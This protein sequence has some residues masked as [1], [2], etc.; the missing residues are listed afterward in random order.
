MIVSLGSGCED[1]GPDIDI[2]SAVPVDV[3]DISLKPIREYVFATG[4]VL[5]TED[6]QL[7]AEQG[8]YYRLKTNPETGKPF[9]MG[10]EVKKG[11]LIV[12]L[13]NP[14][15]V[16]SVQFDSKKI[17][18]DISQREYEKQQTLYDKGGVT[19]RELTDAEQ[20]FIN[21]RYAYDNA[22]LQL[23][24]LS[25]TAPFDGIIVDLNYYSP[26]QKVDVGA[27]IARV[28]NYAQL[29]S[30]V[31]L[32]GK[33]MGRIHVGQEALVTNYAYPDDTLSGEVSQ[34]SPALD[35]DSRTF[36][37][38]V[39]VENPELILRPGMFVKIDIVAAQKDSAVVIPKDII[40]DRRGAK[41]VF[42]VEKGIAM[43]RKIETGLSNRTE[44]EVTS[45]L[46]DG[47]RLVT[48]GYETLQNR[49]RIKVVK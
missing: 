20:T 31:S 3:E 42:V 32:P 39:A 36:K 43:E 27:N 11:D 33:E 26:G 5:A 14:E 48:R 29:Y 34:L 46:K 40:L 2:E 1:D 28:M 37:V 47:E 12:H 45:G 13:D 41:T 16:N 19:L 24:K 35:P 18:F 25:I 21:A 17:N 30:E 49:S 15:F 4:T 10:D 7:T 23:S 44:I 22:S 9:A 38:S 6:A 8:G